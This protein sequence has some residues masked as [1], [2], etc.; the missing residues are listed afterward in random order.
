MKSVHLKIENNC[1]LITLDDQKVNA[2]SYD[3]IKALREA[4]ANCPKEEGVLCLK[5]RPG[6]F[7]AGFDLKVFQKGN[8]KDIKAM[9]MEGFQ[10]LLDLLLF[11][12][13][14]LMLCTGH[15]IGM[16][17]FLLCCADYRLAVNGPFK[18]HAN[19]VVNGM[20]VPPFL[21]EIAKSRIL[22]SHLFPFILNAQ[23]YPIQKGVSVGLL[24]ELCS[25]KQA[26]EKLLSMSQ[27]LSHC[28]HPH[29]QLTKENALSTLSAK[30]QEILSDFDLN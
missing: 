20:Q 28:Q 11:P 17:V 25:E 26:L 13:P 24:D 4:I 16:G 23:S 15:A 3:V 27:Q 9:L 21:M 29:Y 18:L 1:S 30:C 5:G 12:R 10:L 19:E 14:V 2:L 8:M 6:F 7:T 22:S